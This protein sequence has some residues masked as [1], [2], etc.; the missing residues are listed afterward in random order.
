[1]K[2]AISTICFAGV[3]MLTACAQTRK[4]VIFSRAF[5]RVQHPGNLPVDDQGNVLRGSD[6]VRV[7]YLITHDLVSDSPKIQRVQYG[8][9]IFSA[10]VFPDGYEH[11]VVPG[12]LKG[13]EK[14]VVLAAGKNRHYW[15]LQVSPLDKFIPGK[16][17]VITVTGTFRGRKFTLSTNKETELE[18]EI[19]Q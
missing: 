3:M 1:M 15:L 4:P 5:F 9:R 11:A 10:S 18:P 16:K 19:R 12:K 8:N 14:D 13:S 17:N 6:T 7:I 2:R